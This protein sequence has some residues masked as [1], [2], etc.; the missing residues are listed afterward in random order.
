[1][2]ISLPHKLLSKTDIE[3]LDL[4]KKDMKIAFMVLDNGGDIYLTNETKNGYE[5]YYVFDPIPKK[6]KQ[7]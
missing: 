2:Q 1:M 4:P 6:E 5:L 3:K 7:Q